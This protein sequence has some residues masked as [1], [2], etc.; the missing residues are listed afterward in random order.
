MHRST[1][2]WTWAIRVGFYSL[3]V[4]AHVWREIYGVRLLDV[5][6]PGYDYRERKWEYCHSLAPSLHVGWILFFGFLVLASMT[7][8]LKRK[9]TVVLDVASAIGC[10][11]WT[12]DTFMTRALGFT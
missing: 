10:L 6:A 8:G 1:S 2:R 3:I 9:K 5:D 4:A 11:V 7:A 12:W